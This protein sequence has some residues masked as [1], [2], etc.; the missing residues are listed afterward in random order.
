MTPVQIQGICK[1]SKENHQRTGPNPSFEHFSQNLSNKSIRSEIYPM[2]NLQES[3]E[4]NTCPNWSIRPH[5]Q[6]RWGWQPSEPQL[7]QP[8]LVNNPTEQQS[9]EARQAISGLVQ[10]QHT[11]NGN[12]TNPPPS[13]MD[14]SKSMELEI[15][16]W[17]LK[18]NQNYFK[19]AYSRLC[20]NSFFI[21][22]L[23]DKP[24]VQMWN[25]CGSKLNPK[26]GC[27][28]PLDQN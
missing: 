1:K 8:K 13:E 20:F 21:K 2:P 23:L 25:P 14:V 18:F 16:P 19:I 7:P 17:N 4:S 5:R 27:G 24:G 6:G 26:R 9:R 15:N 11:Q 22:S 3:A 12:R 28:N 10:I